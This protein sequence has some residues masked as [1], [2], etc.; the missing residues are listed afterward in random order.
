MHVNYVELNR[1]LQDDFP[2]PARMV[3]LFQQFVHAMEDMNVI[4]GQ[5]PQALPEVLALAN[6]TK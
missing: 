6:L 5:R 1:A 3:T 4:L 2:T